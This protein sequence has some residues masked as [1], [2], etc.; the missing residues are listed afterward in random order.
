VLRRANGEFVVE[1]AKIEG[2]PAGV[3]M[4][5]HGLG[6]RKDTLYAV[7]HAYAKGMIE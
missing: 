7:N 4:H 3:V 6:L 2:F 5:T 1:E